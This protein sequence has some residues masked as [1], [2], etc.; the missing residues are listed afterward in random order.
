MNTTEKI[1]LCLEG[2]LNNT[3]YIPQIQRWVNRH[4]T[5]CSGMK[6]INHPGSVVDD[7]FQTYQFFDIQ[8]DDIVLD[9]GA[10]AGVFSMFVSPW[11]KQVYAVEPM[12]TETLRKNIALNDRK[13]ID[14]V[15]EALGDGVLNLSWQ[16]CKSIKVHGR[17]L[18]YLINRCGGHVDFL[19][20]D[21]EGSE[22]VIHEGELA[23][24]RRIEME[25]HNLDGKHN[26]QDFTLML[27]HAGFH[28][29]IDV[30][31]PDEI[32]MIHAWRV[33]FW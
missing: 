15:D 21:C 10:N 6:F 16:N 29:A 23:G 25:L 31:R 33:A 26:M 7:V 8:R 18:A 9:I 12:M 1:N 22:W 20:C 30:L 19:K 13:N 24:I 17:S 14:F 32:M 27:K 4:N 28:M 11:V 2:M 5:G 3:L